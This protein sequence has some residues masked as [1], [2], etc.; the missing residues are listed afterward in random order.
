MALGRTKEQIAEAKAQGIQPAGGGGFSYIGG[1]NGAI[2][3]YLGNQPKERFNHVHMY[4][5][6]PFCAQLWYQKHLNAPA[7]GRGPHH[8]ES[9]CKVPRGERSWPALQKKGCSACR[10]RVWPSATWRSTGT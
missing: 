4:Q 6:D 9:D 10:K 5:D 2:I 3:E 8:T 7:S 1:P